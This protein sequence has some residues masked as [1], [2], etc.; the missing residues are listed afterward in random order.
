MKIKIK[1][2]SCLFTLFIDSKST[3]IVCENC[4]KRIERETGIIRTG[5]VLSDFTLLKL[6]ENGS[7]VLTFMAHQISLDRTVYLEIFITHENNMLNDAVEFYKKFIILTDITSSTLPFFISANMEYGYNFIVYK[8]FCGKS[9]SQ[10]LDKTKMLEPNLA[11]TII[12]ELIILFVK[13]LRNKD[14]L[15]YFDVSHIYLIESNGIKI[16]PRGI[17]LKYVKGKKSII[18]AFKKICEL[19][20]MM[21]NLSIDEHQMYI[22]LSFNKVKRYVF[23]KN[24]ELHNSL[25]DDF[26]NLLTD[27]EC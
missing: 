12:V 2:Y 14:L 8:F 1:C 22:D 24:I 18:N 15:T 11:R 20:Y 16:S 21:R 4:G 10:C 9:I 23:S 27:H 19:Y 7:S 26:L 25:F 6:V 3:H 5:T 13:I 17:T